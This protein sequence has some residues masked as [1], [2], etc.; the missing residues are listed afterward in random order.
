[1]VE[2][3]K[4]VSGLKQRHQSYRKSSQRVDTSCREKRAVAEGQLH[5]FGIFCF[6]CAVLGRVLRQRSHGTGSYHAR[7]RTSRQRAVEEGAA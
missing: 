2:A 3:E 7:R 6:L 4:M 5:T 1:M